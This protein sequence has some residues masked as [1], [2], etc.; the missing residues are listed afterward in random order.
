MV[1]FLA[2]IDLNRVYKNR[3]N[4]A[5]SEKNGCKVEF[6]GAGTVARCVRNNG[7]S[8]FRSGIVLAPSG[9]FQSD[10]FWWATYGA[11][12]PR[13]MEFCSREFPPPRSF[14]HFRLFLF[15]SCAT[16][17]SREDVFLFSIYF[18]FFFKSLSLRVRFLFILFLLSC[19]LTPLSLS[20]SRSIDR[21]IET[22]CCRYVK[23]ENSDIR[24]IYQSA[25]TQRY[26][27]RVLY[28]QLHLVSLRFM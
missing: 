2:S 25:I 17:L 9:S 21:S 8:S 20:L 14:L 26:S 5:E 22:R 6:R 23:R 1:D 15:P 19:S 10:R 12:G 13:K 24:G 7:G 4:C 18:L 11:S 16:F 3:E 27:A 28:A